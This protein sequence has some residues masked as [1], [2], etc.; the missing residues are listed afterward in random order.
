MDYTDVFSSNLVMELSENIS[1]N[2]HTIKLEEN[3]E[4]SYKPI[5]ALSRIKL[6]TLKT[7][8]KTELK[9]GFIWSSK[10]LIDTLILLDKKLD[11]S[12][13]L[14]VHYWD[15][16]NLSIKNRYPLALMSKSSIG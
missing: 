6:E 4:L 14:C 11:G 7:Y 13:H 8:I 12:F 2:E 16:N 3:K 5:Y 9:T 1:I 10:S 15:L